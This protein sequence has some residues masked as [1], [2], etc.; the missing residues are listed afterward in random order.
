MKSILIIL[1]L[2][3]NYFNLSGQSKTD[4]T[5]KELIYG[6]KDGM[7]LT[8]VMLTPKTVMNGKCI[9]SMISGGWYSNYEWIPYSIKN[10]ETFLERGYTVFLVMHSG[11]PMF[12]ILDAIADAKRAVRFIRFHS[13]EYK[14]DAGHIGMTGTSSGAHLSL[15]VATDDDKPDPSAKDPVDR[16]SSRV[17]A[18]ACFYP[19]S[20][21]I[22]WGN[23]EID[24]MN[25]LVL[26]QA[27]VYAAF[28]F[29]EWD[30]AHKHFVMITDKQK[31]LLI[32]HQISPFYQITPDDPPILIAHGTADIV[33]PFSQSERFI[34]K[35]KQVNLPCD[36]MVKQGGGHGDWK[37]EI[38]Y[39]KAFADWFDKYLK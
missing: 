28:D 9:V 4:Y 26:D 5:E 30:P 18:V 31:L 24:P 22:H 35:L 16:V 2:G 7:A 13:S 17:Q 8:M 21:F 37:D 14:I 39:E 1:L 19:P 23:M 3:L 15:A 25:K 32:S 11:R 33:V 34:E 12:T 36:L 10:S 29:K 20:D 6:R 27:D 38:V